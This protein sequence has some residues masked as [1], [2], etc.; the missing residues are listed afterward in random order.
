MQLED[1]RII[2]HQPAAGGYR[3]IVFEASEIADQTR[4]GQF[5]HLRV[6]TLPDTA[7]RRPFSICLASEGTIHILY[8]EVGIGTAAL[9]ALPE[10]TTVSLIGPLGNGFPVPAADALPLLVGGG[11]GVAPL[12]FL[13]TSLKRPGIL[14]VGGRTA[15]DILLTDEFTAL[16]WE[17]QIAT[18]DGSRGTTG[19][20]TTA[21]DTWLDQHGQ[22]P[23]EWFACGPDGLLRAV[24]DRAIAHNCRA[25]LSLDKHMGCG[26]GACLACVQRL[27]RPDGSQYLGRVCR[28]GPIFEAREIVWEE[29]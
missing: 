6:P 9:A 26:I 7:L 10:G 13:A 18:E 4:P 28:D 22:Q 20:V 27:Q 25:W 17:V 2:L 23:A 12:L 1:A 21:L 15:A 24:G 3:R 14:F 19:L 16:G 5:V 8:K 11:Y 29:A